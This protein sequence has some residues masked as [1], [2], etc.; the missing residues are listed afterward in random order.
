MGPYPLIKIVQIC[1]TIGEQ[2]KIMHFSPLILI[3]YN[4]NHNFYLPLINIVLLKWWG[5][6]YRVYFGRTNRVIYM[7]WKL[8]TLGKFILWYISG[9]YHQMSPLGMEY[10]LNVFLVM[11]NMSILGTEDF[12]YLFQLKDQMCKLVQSF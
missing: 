2:P 5:L 12:V 9:S 3:F 1:A 7:T 6:L 8:W 10:M 11:L 4:Y